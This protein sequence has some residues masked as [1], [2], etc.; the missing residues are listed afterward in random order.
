MVDNNIVLFT[1]SIGCGIG[2]MY[3]YFLY[4]K[5]NQ[6]KIPFYNKNKNFPMFYSICGFVIGGIIGKQLI[7]N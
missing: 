2:Y 6:N 3:G 5:S 4:K 1:A 7:K